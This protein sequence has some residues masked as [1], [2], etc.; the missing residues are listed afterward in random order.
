MNGVTLSVGTN[1]RRIRPRRN[2]KLSEEDS[3]SLSKLLD[4][5]DKIADLI[6]TLQQ[7]ANNLVEEP[8]QELGKLLA[9]RIKYWRFRQSVSLL[10]KME[11]MVRANPELSDLR[12]HPR[13][14]HSFIE[15]G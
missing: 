14:V 2:V 10:K 6:P 9:D 8:T 4:S 3:N 15:Y 5:I 7:W 1:A 12:P 11:E 13:L